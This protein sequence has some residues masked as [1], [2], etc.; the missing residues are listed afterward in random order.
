MHFLNV[1]KE[2]LKESPIELYVDM[3]GV[4]ASYDAG[5]PLDFVNKRPLMEN[6]KK[7]EE[8]GKLKDVELHILS[9]CRK[10][11][12]IEEKNQWLEKNAPFFKK[13][14][15]TIISKEK[16]KDV[17]SSEIKAN[18]LKNL[19]TDKK[20]VVIDDDNMVIKQICKEVANAEV[21]Q[22]SELID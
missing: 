9:I 19:K 2:L 12:Q 16:M 4:I 8:I 20:I 3:D 13:E 18:F 14:Y 6:I 21:F 15:R 10:D 11:F 1:I 5:K 22:D 17:K 7:L